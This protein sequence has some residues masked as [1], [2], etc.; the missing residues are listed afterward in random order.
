MSN[1]S[2]LSD[3]EINKRV[4]ESLGL[5]ARA[6]SN[7]VN[8]GTDENS[9]SVGFGGCMRTVDYCNNWADA[10]QIIVENKICTVAPDGIN[11]EWCAYSWDDEHEWWHENPLRAAMIVFLM[12]KEQAND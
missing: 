1:Y 12:M 4:A 6:K 8:Y 2:E 9:V 7:C 5:Y 11:D 3:F 10:G